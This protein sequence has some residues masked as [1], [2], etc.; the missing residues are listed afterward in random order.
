MY[1][2]ESFE[3]AGQIDFIF[4]NCQDLIRK[5]ENLNDKKR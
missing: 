1:V 4:C 3:N 2:S 5:K